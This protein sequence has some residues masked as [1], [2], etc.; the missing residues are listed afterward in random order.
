MFEMVSR[1]TVRKVGPRGWNQRLDV[2]QKDERYSS[3]H[4]PGPASLD[5]V[6]SSAAVIRPDDSTPFHGNA[7]RNAHFLTPQAL[8]V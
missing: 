8:T 6:F 1:M 7:E 3:G 5:T 4:P 2:A